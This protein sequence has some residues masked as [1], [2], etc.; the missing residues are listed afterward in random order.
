MP[1]IFINYRTGDGAELAALFDEDLSRRF[2]SDKV[3]RASKSIHPSQNYRNALAAASA[4]TQVLL[5]V[6][7]PSWLTIDDD[8]GTTPLNSAENWTRKEI[9]NAL[10]CG[11]YIVPVLCGR[12]TS[13]LRASQLPADLVPLADLQAVRFDTG[14]TQGDLTKLAA[15]LTELVP[16]LVDKTTDHAKQ[17]EPGS[18]GPEESASTPRNASGQRSISNS[19]PVQGNQVT[20]DNNAFYTT[21]NLNVSNYVG[22]TNTG[23]QTGT[24]NGNLNQGDERR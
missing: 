14:N 5:V 12:N 15:A 10:G 4:G 3:F 23:V 16:G 21:P 1:E 11:A 7:G 9:V 2:G 17:D 19:G 22:G 6:I 13:Q 24:F 18:R 8:H 20:G